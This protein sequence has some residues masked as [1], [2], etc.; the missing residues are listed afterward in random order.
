[1]RPADLLP[2]NAVA[3]LIKFLLPAL[4]V[5]VWLRAVGFPQMLAN[6]SEGVGALLQIIG[7]LYSVLY[8][9]ATYVIW[10]QFT[11]VESE[12]MKES[13][14]L[15]DLVLFSEGL[16]PAVREPL[17]QAVRAYAKEVGDTEWPQL[18][19][20]EPTPK[21]DRL[22]ADIVSTLAL[23]KPA[24]DNERTVYE[25]LLDIVNQASA[26]RDERIALSVK[27]VPR[28]LILLVTLTAFVLLLLL[29]VYP[30]H[31]AV[32]GVGALAITAT[33]L[34]LAHFVITDL[35][36]PFTGV[37]NVTPEAFNQLFMKARH[38]AGGA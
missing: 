19:S 26:R 5:Y 27:R 33:L 4:I 7:T 23:I 28:T 20:G 12:I 1:M 8:A 24:D 31:S 30:F 38:A 17:L 18:A 25:R 34:F 15:K 11:A 2:P 32:I 13:G 14:A 37:W 36:N 10:G 29:F 16:R 6:D 9:F 3:R 21:T 22:F 35:D